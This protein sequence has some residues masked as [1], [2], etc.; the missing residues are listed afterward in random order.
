VTLFVLLALL[1]LVAYAANT[2]SH[3][4]TTGFPRHSPIATGEKLK[5][6][7]VARNRIELPTR[8]FSVGT[9]ALFEHVKFHFKMSSR[10]NSVPRTFLYSFRPTLALF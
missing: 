3:G 10:I 5:R 6:I 9:R 8:G 1:G 4:T 2:E 7:V